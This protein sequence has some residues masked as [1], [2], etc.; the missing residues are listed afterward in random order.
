MKNRR[1]MVK[2]NEH[3]LREMGDTTKLANMHL[4]SMTGKG[5]RERLEKI[6]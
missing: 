4:A 1:K 5:E 2:K 6:I 3:S